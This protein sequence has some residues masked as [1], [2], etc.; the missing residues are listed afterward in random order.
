[1]QVE[2]E[3]QE[4]ASALLLLLP[5]RS[6]LEKQ[7]SDLDRA[8][9]FLGAREWLPGHHF[10]GVLAPIS[11]LAHAFYGTPPPIPHSP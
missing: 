10:W 9:Q 2:V 6:G 1:M 5:F 4:R 3:V 8:V 11:V 7:H